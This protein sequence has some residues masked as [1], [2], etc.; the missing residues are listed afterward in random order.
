MEEEEEEEEELP[1]GGVS[2]DSGP[3]PSFFR[4]GRQWELDPNP[5]GSICR[6]PAACCCRWKGEHR[7]RVG[8]AF[9]VGGPRLAS[10]FVPTHLF[11]G[12][13]SCFP[14]GNHLAALAF[15]TWRPLR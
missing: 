10:F 14:F 13:F 7:P 8:E 11:L 4:Q 1:T 3:D 9:P 12:S 5:F 2:L 15:S 6:A